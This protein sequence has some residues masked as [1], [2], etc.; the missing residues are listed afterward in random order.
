M[1]VTQG[2]WDVGSY[3]AN[4]GEREA[5]SQLPPAKGLH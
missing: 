1:P 5:D 3:D 4:P 2:Q